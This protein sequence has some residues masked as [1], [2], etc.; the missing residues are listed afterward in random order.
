[1][2]KSEYQELVEFLGKKFGRIDARFD[3]VDQRFDA[4]DQRFDA[5][6]E[7]LVR[8]EVGVER[9]RDDIRAVAER[10]TALDRKLDRKIGALRSEMNARF[11]DQDELIRL[12]YGD[13]ARRID[14]LEEPA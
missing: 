5:V 9:N 4:I 2:T 7:R 12:G 11:D 10:V 14:R 6:D 8:V 3:A 13:L 1:M